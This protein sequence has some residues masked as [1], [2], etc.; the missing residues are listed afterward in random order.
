MLAAG[1][2]ARQAILPLGRAWA[3]RSARR[4]PALLSYAVAGTLAAI[5]RAALEAW[6]GLAG[7]PL[8]VAF[9]VI[10]GVTAGLLLPFARKSPGETPPAESGV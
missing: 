10:W 5:S 4:I 8:W 1:L 9:G 6:L 2:A 7:I 3:T